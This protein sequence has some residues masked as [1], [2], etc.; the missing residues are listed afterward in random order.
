MQLAF[1]EALE[2]VIRIPQTPRRTFIQRIG[3]DHRLARQH[4]LAHEL[5]VREAAPAFDFH[6]HPIAERHPLAR[7][8][9]IPMGRKH[10]KEDAPCWNSWKSPVPSAANPLK[11]PWTRRP[12]RRIT[13]R[14]ARCAAGRSKSKCA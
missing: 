2:E 3:E 7:R 13:S 11:P 14:I 12:A 10:V 1:A 8:I 5:R 4:V 9:I 6:I